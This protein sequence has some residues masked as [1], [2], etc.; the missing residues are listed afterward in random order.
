MR[1]VEDKLERF[2]NDIMTDVL[3]QKEA[4]QAEF[5]Y[6]YDQEF[7]LKQTEY[8]TECYNIVQAGLKKIDKEKH[9]ILSKAT[10]ENKTMLLN[11]RTYV[12][13]GVFKLA[14]KKL[15]DFAASEQ[16]FPYLV[17]M[18]EEN[19]AQIGSGDI[20]IYI[21]AADEMHLSDLQKTFNHVFQLENKNI[22]LLGGCKLINKTAGLFIDDSFAKRLYDQRDTFLQNCQIKVEV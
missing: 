9:E 3:T 14:E 15:K 17:K 13:E 16:Y 20:E 2:R 18:I 10:L 6:A 1:I 21:N 12:I 5:N 19:L 7:D 22:E 11:K 8:L 4:I